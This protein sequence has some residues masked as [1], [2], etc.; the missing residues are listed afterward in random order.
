MKELIVIIGTVIL[1][2][3]IFNMMTG[4]RPDSLRSAAKEMME[5]SLAV[6]RQYEAD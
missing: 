5:Q 1:G 6:S 4:D 2:A 3:Y